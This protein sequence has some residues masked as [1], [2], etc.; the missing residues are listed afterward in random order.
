MIH[1]DHNLH[2]PHDF[3]CTENMFLKI[4]FVNGS[5]TISH[6]GKYLGSFSLRAIT[7]LLKLF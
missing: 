3:T 7:S 4:N 1:I 6:I 2:N 5:T